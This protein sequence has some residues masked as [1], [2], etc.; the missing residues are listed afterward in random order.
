MFGTPG[1]NDVGRYDNIII[2]V[3]DGKHSDS[4]PAFTIDVE[5]FGNGA[6]TLSWSIPTERTDN[7]TLRNLKGF[8]IYYGQSSG[9]Y[10][11]KVTLNNSSL[12]SHVV[13]NLSSGRWYFVI[14]AFDTDGVESN[15]SNEGSKLF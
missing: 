1:T 3:S 13:D 2:S 10:A 11:N 8:H 7:T 6:A 14:T 15:P 5:A 12:S 9:D 4:L